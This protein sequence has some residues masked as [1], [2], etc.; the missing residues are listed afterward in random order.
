MPQRKNNR[1]NNPKKNKRTKGQNGA[2]QIR[3][4]IL[5]SQPKAESEL[6]ILGSRKN[7]ES[8]E[9]YSQSILEEKLAAMDLK[10]VNPSERDRDIEELKKNPRAFAAKMLE[11]ASEEDQS[12]LL[13]FV[14]DWSEEDKRIIHAFSPQQIRDILETLFEAAIKIPSI[15]N[16]NISKMAGIS[17]MAEGA[18]MGSKKKLLRALADREETRQYFADS[19]RTN[20]IH[21]HRNGMDEELRAS[22]KAAKRANKQDRAKNPIQKCA[23]C[24]T[25]KPV[26]ELQK[27]VKCL[28]VWYCNRS[29]QV[30][31]WKNGHK[32]ECKAL[33][34]ARMNASH[35]HASLDG[36]KRLPQLP[37]CVLELSP[38]L[39]G[40][41]GAA[42]IVVPSWDMQDKAYHSWA[43]KELKHM[44]SLII[45]NIRAYFKVET[46][47]GDTTGE[48]VGNMCQDSFTLFIL[49]YTG[50]DGNDIR[51]LEGDELVA[52]KM[53]R[54][55]KDSMMYPWHTRVPKGWT[56]PAEAVRLMDAETFKEL[57]RGIEFI[58]NT[59][60]ERDAL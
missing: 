44:Q 10:D 9:H 14:R 41:H 17:K 15:D 13:S 37:S 20:I 2:A 40:Y 29:C 53:G 43:R 34:S 59:Y 35:H 48:M 26:T 19:I 50:P 5:K 54:T 33:T 30:R 39:T 22:Y 25:S 36:V 1:K 60:G 4:D 18:T 3:N 12:L 11:A 21:K 32:K 45:K 7:V 55:K 16:K 56:I 24:G 38:N 52:V 8:W 6:K 51:L 46:L 23:G 49:G 31:H 57:Q 58:R 27:C 47:G 28:S 42:Y